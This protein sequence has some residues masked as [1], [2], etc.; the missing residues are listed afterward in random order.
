MSDGDHKGKAPASH[1]RVQWVYE[2]KTRDELAQ[3]YD[4]WAKDY[5]ADLSRDFGYLA[6]Q[7]AVAK[8]A[9]LLGADPLILDAG[10]GTGLVGEALAAAGLR[11]I[12]GIDMSQGMLDAARAKGLYQELRQAVLGEPLDFPDGRFDACF[13]I[14][15]LTLGHAPAKSLQEL[16]RVTHDAEVS[17]DAGH[18]PGDCVLCRVRIL[19][20]VDHEVEIPV[21][22]PV[23][24]IWEVPEEE[25]GLH[26]HVVEI[27][28]S[29][30]RQ[31][32]LVTLVY[33]V[34]NLGEVALHPGPEAVDAL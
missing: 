1:R 5:D 20:L 22:V 29:G 18:L 32:V 11:R 13:C 17:M 31:E 30:A 3:R 23:R 2:A 7:L 34:G 10:V 21:A 16:V 15:T 26:Q 24:D 12:V 8:A 33:P 9:P 19:E 28:G 4:S 14:G 25:V 27:D 6:P